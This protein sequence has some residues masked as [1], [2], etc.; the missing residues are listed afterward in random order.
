MSTCVTGKIANN[1]QINLQ[2]FFL[3]VAV[4]FM[5]ICHDLLQSTVI[6]VLSRVQMNLLLV[7]HKGTLLVRQRQREKLLLKT[8]IPKISFCQNL[9]HEWSCET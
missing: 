2:C 4:Y 7:Y 5:K 6:S 8:K 1:F 3:T 9:Q